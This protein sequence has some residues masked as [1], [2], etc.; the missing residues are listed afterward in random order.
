MF[1]T[2][3]CIIDIEIKTVF[4]YFA[5]FSKAFDCINRGHSGKHLIVIVLFSH[6]DVEDEM[7]A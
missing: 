7:G 5:D 2:V 1:T 3:V 4:R 6:I